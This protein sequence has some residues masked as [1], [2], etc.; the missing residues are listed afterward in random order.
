MDH[1]FIYFFTLLM[2]IERP[3]VYLKKSNIYLA[4]KLLPLNLILYKHSDQK[5][6]KMILFLVGGCKSN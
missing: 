3:N 2:D 6:N 5:K 4:E 1:S